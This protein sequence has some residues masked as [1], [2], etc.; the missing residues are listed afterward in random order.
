[1]I[2]Y[3]SHGVGPLSPPSPQFSCSKC[4]EDMW[5][6]KETEICNECEDAFM[7]GEL[8]MTLSDGREVTVF[9]EADGNDIGICAVEHNGSDITDY[10]EFDVYEACQFDVIDSYMA[11]LD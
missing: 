10:D 11:Y 5:E 2:G 1:M 8:E 7:D 6:Y 9:Y 3:S 4:G